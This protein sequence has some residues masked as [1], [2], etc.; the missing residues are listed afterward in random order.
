VR[1]KTRI[2]N[3]VQEVPGI[4]SF[5]LEPVDGSQLVPFTPGAHI[6]VFLDEGL[7]RSYSLINTTDESR[8]YHIA[9]K[10]ETEG[11]GGSRKMHQL[12][13]GQEL[14]VSEPRNNFPLADPPGQSILLAGGIGITP[15]YGMAKHLAAL[16]APFKLHYLVRSAQDAAFLNELREEFDDRLVSALG[17][18][19][20]AVTSHLERLLSSEPAGTHLYI[21][22]PTPLM[23]LGRK[24][25]A[26]YPAINLHLEYFSADP[27]LDQLPK[28]TFQV[29]LAR[30][31]RTITIPEGRTIIEVLA[32]NDLV[33][34]TSCEQGIC[35]I[36]MTKV[37]EGTP[38]HRDMLMTD[39]EHAAN[40]QMT[41]C[42][43]RSIGPLLVLDL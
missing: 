27:A 21:C 16:R 15:I 40:D 17:L 30:T 35:G 23:D 36:C 5:Y 42:V 26:K 12:E 4:H 31:G 8:R 11:R 37:L 13:I 25:A 33:I 10:Q 9:V 24:I 7:I 19:V 39:E 38:D 14:E 20:E 2:Q 32:E 28:G 3:I 1:Q 18:D 6:D 29:K 34:E 41:I 43:S 22:G